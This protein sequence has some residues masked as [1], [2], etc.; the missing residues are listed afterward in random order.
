METRSVLN[1][2]QTH[3]PEQEKVA[4][5]VD[6]LLRLATLRTKLI[7]DVADYERV[8]WVSTVPHE[9][10]CFTQAWGR[11]EEHEPDEWLE[12][13]N[14]W[15]P[16]LPVVPVQCKDWVSLPSL[17]NKN[18][19]PELLPEITRQIPNP[20]WVEESDQPETIPQT[21][22]LED[23]P[24]VQGAWDRYVEDKWLPWTEEHNVWEKVHKVYSSLF[25]I[26]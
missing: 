16:E 5:L 19:L 12:V 6:Y 14:R 4:R 26:Y 11:D 15:E 2:Q 21:E 22:H 9:R 24:E 3:S 8:L 17:R 7:R 18:D 13:Q 20:D 10:G 25:A 23:H 1:N